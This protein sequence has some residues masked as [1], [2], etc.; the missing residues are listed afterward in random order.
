[1]QK[2]KTFLTKPHKTKDTE[3]IRKRLL[4]FSEDHK[5]HIN[6]SQS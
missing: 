3:T 6:K 4:K 5:Y 2:Q 1:M